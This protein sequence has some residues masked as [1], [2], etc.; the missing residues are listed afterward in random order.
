MLIGLTGY[1]GSGKDTVARILCESYGFKRYAFA[2]K[3]REFLYAQNPIVEVDAEFGYDYGYGGEVFQTC[4]PV[5]KSL[6]EIVSG[7]GWDRAK[8]EYPEVRELM[9]RTGVW[10]RENVYEDFWVKLVERDIYA[11]EPWTANIVIADVRFLNEASWIQTAQCVMAPRAL[12]RIARVGVGP[13]NDHISEA[14]DFEADFRISNNGTLEDL[15]RYVRILV[16]RM[17]ED[18]E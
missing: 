4:E 13:A 3:L 10:F 17:E 8:R 12:V 2:D 6:Q 14:L 11:Q 16:D 7:I 1:A 9:Q 5:A 18:Y 15:K